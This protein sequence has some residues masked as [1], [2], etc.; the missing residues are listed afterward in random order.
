V[1]AALALGLAGRVAVACEDGI[2]T[3][4]LGDGVGDAGLVEAIG[5]AGT[6]A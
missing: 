3:V 4:V 6:A 5:T 1:V 2:G